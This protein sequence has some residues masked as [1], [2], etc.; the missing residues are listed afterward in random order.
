M[1]PKKKALLILSYQRLWCVS[2]S[3]GPDAWAS[4][5]LGRAL[6]SSSRWYRSPQGEPGPRGRRPLRPSSGGRRQRAGPHD[7]QRRHRLLHLPGHPA[8]Q[9]RRRPVQQVGLR[10]GCAAS[11]GERVPVGPPFLSLSPPVIF[12]ISGCIPCPWPCFNPHRWCKG[13]Q[14]SR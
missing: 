11:H 3:N 13:Q 7:R 4:I 8:F 1:Q 12:S 2:V 9:R 10:K 6:L 5:T 14:L